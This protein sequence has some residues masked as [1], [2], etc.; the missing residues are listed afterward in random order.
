MTDYMITERNIQT[1]YFF[2]PS[3]GLCVRERINDRWGRAHSI[4]REACDGFCVYCD[5]GE[6]VHIICANQKNNI[7][8]LTKKGPQVNQYLLSEGSPEIFPIKF[9]MLPSGNFLNLFYSAGYHDEFL[10][11]HCILGINSQPATVD[12][13]MRTA[14]EF[15]ISAN[16]VYYTNASGILGYQDYGD[17]KPARFIPVSQDGK[18][19]CACRVDQKIFLA[20]KKKNMLCIN[21]RDIFEDR[22]AEEPVLVYSDNRLILQWRSGSFIRYI[23]SFDRGKTW[24]SPMRFM[25]NGYSPAIFYIPSSVYLNCYYGHN[26]PN[27]PVIYEYKHNPMQAAPI[28]EEPPQPSPSETA[29]KKND[30]LALKKLRIAIDLLNRE[31]KQLKHEVALLK[32]AQP[33]SSPEA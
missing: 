19:P 31:V 17:G 23:V 16:R 26:L 9:M 5:A 7:L 18:M 8:Y 28:H 27:G 11:V 24:S 29:Q 25:S 13:L 10:L 20:Y 3:E 33:P 12:K 21:D 30:D 4:C 2:S 22:S 15:F 6:V 32:N 14:P 1:H